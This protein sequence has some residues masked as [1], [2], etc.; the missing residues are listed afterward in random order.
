MAK[1]PVIKL[2]KPKEFNVKFKRSALIYGKNPKCD[3]LRPPD[4][5][6][7]RANTDLTKVINRK[8]ESKFVRGSLNIIEHSRGN[9]YE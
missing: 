6:C 1:K 9:F 2:V 8:S 4:I 7:T 5:D 3:V